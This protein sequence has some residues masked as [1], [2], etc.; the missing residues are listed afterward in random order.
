MTTKFYKYKKVFVCLIFFIVL[1]FSISPIFAKPAN[2]QLFVPVWDPANLKANSVTAVTNTKL[3]V[4][5]YILD[6]VLYKM[7]DL[8]IKRMTAS[9]VNWIN[10]GFKGKPAYVT[11]PTAYFQSIGDR[12][13][14]NFIANNPNLNF[15]CGPISARIKIALAQSYSGYNESWQCT[16][17]DAYGNMEDFINDFE[18]G[19]WDKFFRLTQEPQ[20]NPI[21]AYLQAEGSLARAIAQEV[22]EKDKEL[23]WGRGFMSFK[24][25]PTGRKVVGT[26]KNPDGSNS[27]TYEDGVTLNQQTVPQVG[28]CGVKEQTSTPGSVIQEK[29]DSVL[30]IGDKRIAVANEINEIISALLNQLTQRI[31]GG[32]GSG[33]KGLSGS[34]SANNSQSTSFTSLLHNPSDDQII[35]DYVRSSNENLINEAST[36]IP[37]PYE[38]FDN[39]SLPECSPPPTSQ[40]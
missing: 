30:T 27:V 24:T 19:G 22:G 3:T 39:P 32:I 18:R 12:V 15:L 6:A 7:I 5:E 38:C 1:V 37:N 31:V 11:D 33:L 16:L 14:G 28:D 29:L 20:N 35:D 2:A 4:K 26:V 40:F 21:G 9:T 36:P 25:C 8:I 23:S 34:D 17:S 13:A 10:S